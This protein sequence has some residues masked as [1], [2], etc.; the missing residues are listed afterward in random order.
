MALVRVPARVEG[1][2]VKVQAK[3]VVLEQVAV[4]SES[5]QQLGEVKPEPHLRHRHTR[6][7]KEARTGQ[8]APR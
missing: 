5:A 3:S 7:A 1:G 8:R 2:T 4:V 6:R